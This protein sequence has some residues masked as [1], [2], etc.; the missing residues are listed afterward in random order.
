MHNVFNEGL[1][2]D[3][4]EGLLRRLKN[5][6]D[7]NKKQLEKQLKTIK[8]DSY[9]E[10]IVKRL[11]FINRLGPDAIEILDEIKEQDKEI[12]YTKLVCT[13]RNGKVYGFN[14]F[15]R[16]GVLLEVFILVIFG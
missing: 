5:L 4:K 13:H 11:K 2:G 10:I 3:R 8:N 7:V 6:E 16:L 14:I 9:N 15:R 1:E 12:D